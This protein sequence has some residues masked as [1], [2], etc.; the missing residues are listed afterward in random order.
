MHYL[1]IILGGR[2]SHKKVGF[3]NPFRMEYGSSV[4]SYMPARYLNISTI[5]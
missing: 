3:N 2:R 5:I 4:V 1:W